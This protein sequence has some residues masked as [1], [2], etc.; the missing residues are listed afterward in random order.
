MSPNFTELR[1]C[2]FL[3]ET[4]PA[5]FRQVVVNVVLATDIFD[6]ELNDLQKSR[7]AKVFSEATKSGTKECS[8][9][10][11][12]IVIEHI[13][14]ASDASHTMQHWHGHRKWNECLSKKCPRRSKRDEWAWIQQCFGTRAKSDSSVQD[15]APCEHGCLQCV[16]T[17]FHSCLFFALFT[18]NHIVPLAKKLAECNA[19]GVSSDECLNHAELNRAEWEERGKPLSPKWWKKCIRA[20]RTPAMRTLCNGQRP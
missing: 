2:L 7:W 5:R 10:H 18:H 16:G 14:Q 20:K 1:G 13:V 12:A 3:T 9:M 6:K 15:S 11:A 17:Q 8:D 4:E 19:F